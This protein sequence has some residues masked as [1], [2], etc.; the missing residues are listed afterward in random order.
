MTTAIEHQV[1]SPASAQPEIDLD[2][3]LKKSKKEALSDIK[4][5]KEV[6]RITKFLNNIKSSKTSDPDFIEKMEGD[7]NPFLENLFDRSQILEDRMCEYS[8]CFFGLSDVLLPSVRIID[9]SVNVPDHEG[10]VHTLQRGDLIIKYQSGE[11]E[12]GYIIKSGAYS[13]RYKEKYLSY[14]TELNYQLIGQDN[15]T[16][17]TDWLF[18]S[19][20]FLSALAIY[21]ATGVTT[22]AIPAFDQCILGEIKDTYPNKKI[23][24]FSESGQD[25]PI[26]V[27]GVSIAFPL[28]RKGNSW[29]ECRDLMNK[30]GDG[31]QGIKYFKDCLRTSMKHAL[32]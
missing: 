13:N 32:H 3:V 17:N 2:E 10:K 24:W 11:G 22:I 25:I 15:C 4:F 14:S 1:F 20:N 29:S 8:E 5:I 18:L 16:L 21:A 6:E 27:K 23:M 26:A 31:E 9:D 28:E 30:M 7:T 19:D 12:A